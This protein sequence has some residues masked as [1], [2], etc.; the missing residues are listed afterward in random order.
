ML[1]LK[2]IFINLLEPLTVPEALRGNVCQLIDSSPPLLALVSS[3]ARQA[4]MYF[5]AASGHNWK[6]DR[7]VQYD[8]YIIQLISYPGEMSRE[9]ICTSV[10]PAINSRNNF[11]LHQVCT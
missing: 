6:K 2:D 5:C 10:S 9:G 11:Q 3:S 4:G 7:N 1:Q 8:S